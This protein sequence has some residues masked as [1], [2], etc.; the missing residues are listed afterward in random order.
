MTSKSRAELARAGVAL[1]LA[2]LLAP[3]TPRVAAVQAQPS[4]VR[5]GIR[6]G[7]ITRLSLRLDEWTT[8]GDLAAAQAAAA[9]GRDVV[10]NDLTISGLFTLTQGPAVLDSTALAALAEQAELAVELRVAGS[11]YQLHALLYGMPGRNL[12]ADRAYHANDVQLRRA[13]H[14]LSDD[15]VFALSGEKGIAQ[16]QIAYAQQTGSG[17][18]VFVAD[19][20]GY[21]ARQVTHDRNLDFSPAF[22]PDGRS[23]AYSSMRGRGFAICLMDL[24]TGKDRVL[25]GYPG[26]SLSPAFSP[27]G[28]LLAFASSKDGNHEIYAVRLDGTGLVRLTHNPG[29]DVQP[30]WSPNGRQLAFCSDRAGSPQIYVM[31]GDGSNVRRLTSDEARNESPSWSPRGSL[32]AF[33]TRQGNGYDVCAT[34]VTGGTVYNLTQGRGSNESPH[35]APDGRHLLMVS[36]RDGPARLYILNTDNGEIFPLPVS[37]NVQTPA[38]YR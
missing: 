28:Q 35:W 16:T 15:V 6:R 36:S 7:A 10:R 13:I 12:I 25:A 24:A 26:S 4:E 21:G 17:R 9:T 23:L 5:I 2:V 22:S 34:Q 31:D 27:D 1:L 3:E 32:L 11:D 33:M 8:S 20:D 19:Y 38:W 37:G 18:E 14:Q 30:T 29:I